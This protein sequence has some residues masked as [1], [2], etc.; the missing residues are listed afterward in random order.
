MHRKG[1]N[2]SRK[3]E[4]F[5]DPNT[6]FPMDFSF[7]TI[8]GLRLKSYSVFLTIFISVLREKLTLRAK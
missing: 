5:S 4:N 6:V 8:E 2:P 3:R 7:L 1:R